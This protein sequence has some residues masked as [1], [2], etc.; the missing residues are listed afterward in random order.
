[1]GTLHVAAYH[2]DIARV[3]LLIS[4]GSQVDERDERG[5][6]PLLWSCF[7]GAVG[8][9]APVTEALIA[10]GADPNAIT[11]AGDSNCIMLAA[12]S[13]SESAVA[14]VLDGG[15][16]VD[17]SADGVTALMVAA[18][19]GNKPIVKL[20]LRM[21]ADPSIK[22]GAYTAAHYAQYGGDDELADLISKAQPAN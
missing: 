6:T 8:D 19:A 9:P 18:R 7:K 11:S 22:C 4:N 14:A 15:G 3:R 1:M 20:L 10:A 5:Y 2:A 21:G 13:G 12:Q 16:L 17:G